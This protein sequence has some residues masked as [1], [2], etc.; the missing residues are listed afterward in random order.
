MKEGDLTEEE[1]IGPSRASEMLW[2]FPAHDSKNNS[3]YNRN[4]EG[5]R[6][7]SLERKEFFA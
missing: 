4:R 3:S 7:S 6:K 5:V 2:M 1:P